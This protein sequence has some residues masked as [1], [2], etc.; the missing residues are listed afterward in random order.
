MQKSILTLLAVGALSGGASGCEDAEAAGSEQSMS[1]P[2]VIQAMR[3]DRCR[4]AP[5]NRAYWEQRIALDN[6]DL[7]RLGRE[8]AAA[9]NQHAR[10]VRCYTR[11]CIERERRW[12]QI[13]NRIGQRISVAERSK[14]EHMTKLQESTN[15]AAD[16]D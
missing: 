8:Y 1:V 10:A 4:R 5:A 6:S 16:C 15:D 9:F 14:V 2:A 12:A 11:A 7:E 3:A 13:I